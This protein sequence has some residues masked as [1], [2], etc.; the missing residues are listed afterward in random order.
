MPKNTGFSRVMG[1]LILVL[2]LAGCNGGDPKPPPSD[3]HPPVA[4]FTSSATTTP[5][6]SALSFDAS[7]S[8]DPDGD[9]LSFSWDFGDGEFGGSNKVA[10]V[11]AA[12][13]SFTVKLTVGDGKGGTNSTQKTVTVSSSG[14]AGAKVNVTGMVAGIA[15]PVSGV[16]V[17]DVNG[18]ASSSTDA[19]GKVNLSLSVGVPHTLKLSK[20]GFADQFQPINLPVGNTEG[21]FKAGMIARETAQTLNSSN[22]GNLTGK[23]GAKITLGTAAL[24][25]SDGNPVT[26]D[27]QISQ[28]PV[29]ISGK[30][31]SSFPGAFAGVK[32]DGTQTPIA[33]YGT[34]EFSLQQ[35]GERLQLV[36]GKTA[37]IE[38]PVYATLN[39]DGSSLKV[40]DTSP[41]WSLDE[42]TGIWVQEGTGV[43]VASSASP[44]L[45]ALRAEVSHFSWWNHDV[46]LEKPYLPKPKCFINPGPEFQPIPTPCSIGPRLPGE[47]QTNAI[48]VN[49]RDIP[50]GFVRPPGFNVKAEIPIAGGLALSVPAN[51]DFTLDACSPNGVYCG[52]VVVHGASGIS[53]DINITLNPL[54]SAGSCGSP[55]AITAPLEADYSLASITQANC[56]GFAGLAGQVLNLDVK[57]TLNSNLTGSVVLLGTNGQVIKQT[58]FGTQLGT[59]E[60]V[61]PSSGAYQIKISGATNAPGGYHLSVAVTATTPFAPETALEDQ[62]EAGVNVKYYSFI[63]QPGDKFS[64]IA[65]DANQANLQLQVLGL[66]LPAQTISDGANP[67][68]LESLAGGAY[69]FKV[70]HSNHA[71]AIP[72]GLRVQKALA[73]T[74]NTP[75]NGAL[76]NP[77]D[78]RVYAFHANAGAFLNAIVK[79]PTSTSSYPFVSFLRVSFSGTEG[80]FDASSNP[81]PAQ[82]G[83]IAVTSS[84]TFWV[85]VST[86]LSST[87]PNFTLGV[88]V[89]QPPAALPL[90]GAITTTSGSIDTLGAIKLYSLN[91]TAKDEVKFVLS[92]PAALFASLRV[93]GPGSG[94]VFQGVPLLPELGLYNTGATATDVFI[95]PETGQYVVAIGNPFPNSGNVDSTLTAN[96]TGNFVFTLLKPSVLPFNPDVIALTTVAL[97]VPFGFD[98]YAL[99]VP[100]TGYYNL[101]NTLTGSQAIVNRSLRDANG[102]F[103]Q[104]GDGLVK[105]N[106]GTYSLEMDSIR[107]ATSTYQLNVATIEAPPITI[108]SGTPLN[109]NIDSPGERDFYSFVGAGTQITI[110]VTPGAGLTGGIIIRKRFMAGEF[111]AGTQVTL[112]DFSNPIKFTPTAGSEYVI[113]ITSQSPNTGLYT[114][115][116]YIVALN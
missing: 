100:T 33:S 102:T 112:Q 17:T 27:V 110:T 12:A 54:L 93:F 89:L 37:T 66:G 18:A 16:T 107:S 46:F 52:E 31:V 7:T 70:S 40:G 25:D 103:I 73:L 22:G 20:T 30:M 83:A 5:A 91:L 29:D 39:F 9:A 51:I 6:L 82:T 59:L 23:D 86:N 53:E 61:I 108:S 77:G 32:P 84:G 13:G 26:G 57:R 85:T 109:G 76:P 67:I 36:P 28:T 47:F 24:V 55:T 11:F 115:G 42:K 62:L 114:T 43:I 1:L 63:A 95:A 48:S 8:S 92:S 99:S 113:E 87:E 88:A 81:S 64:V 96:A 3:N 50:A 49:P 56:F 116:T 71:A 101:I 45:L 79:V 105:L 80:S 34:V 35:N 4:A 97:N 106:P 21:F 10:H 14:T 15:G 68:N 19:A 38:I 65:R 75:V 41:L 69:A 58:D 78:V 74:P 44:T 90:T 98:R 60:V 2:T 72:F 94:N 104:Q 111:Y